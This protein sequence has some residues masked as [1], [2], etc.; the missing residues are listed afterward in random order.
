MNANITMTEETDP[1]E[2]AAAQARREKFDRNYAW[3][4]GHATEVYSHRGKYICVAGQELFVG[5]DLTQLLAQAKAAHPDDDGPL[6][7]YVPKERAARIYAHRW[8]VAG[9]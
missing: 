8:S 9:L 6:F 5:D 7:Q 1:V 2:I 4:E 3:L